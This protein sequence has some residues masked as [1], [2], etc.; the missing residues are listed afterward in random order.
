[1]ER[2][3]VFIH[4]RDPVSRAG[5]A[6][7]LR[8]RPEIRVVEDGPQEAAVAILVADEIDDQLVQ[9]AQALRRSH[10]TRV[11]VVATRV[12]DAGLMAAVEAGAG[13]LIRRADATSAALAEAV[14]RVADGEATIPD[15][16]LAR[17]LEQVERLQRQVLDPRG[18][19]FSGLSEREIEVLKLVAEGHDTSDIAGRLCYSERTIK[20]VLHDV[21]T[22]L[23]LKNRTHAVAYAMR[24]GLI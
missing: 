15:D 3:P 24:Q 21:T 23:N 13:S 11:L 18:L 4:A 9:A 6:T 5:I 14:E 16:L 20:N 19:R 22:R 2:V 8:S 10:G 12:D 7:E 17:L 1:M